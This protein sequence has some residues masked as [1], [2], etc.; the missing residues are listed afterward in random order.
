MTRD[1]TFRKLPRFNY[2]VHILV[3]TYSQLM[4][5]IIKQSNNH[6]I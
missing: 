4:Q 1:I 6:N 3:P 5:I 2:M